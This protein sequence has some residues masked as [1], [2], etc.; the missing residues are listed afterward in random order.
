MSYGVGLGCLGPRGRRERLVWAAERF[1]VDIQ[2]RLHCLMRAK[3]I[4]RA[5]LA[6]LMGWKA[7]RVERLFSDEHDITLRTL[8][9]LCHA[10][11]ADI[12]VV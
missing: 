5:Q 4:D 1:R 2:Y 11:G 8:G 9:A 6:A 10:L 3:G 12:E 7:E